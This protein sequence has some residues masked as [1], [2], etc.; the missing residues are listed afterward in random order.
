MG[1]ERR[2]GGRAWSLVKVCLAMLFHPLNLSKLSETATDF[3]DG[4]EVERDVW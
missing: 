4:G 1:M 2:E 3:S